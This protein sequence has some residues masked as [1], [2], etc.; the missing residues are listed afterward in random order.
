[1]EIFHLS[2]VVRRF[3]VCPW[4][5]LGLLL[6]CGEHTAYRHLDTALAY[7][8]QRDYEPALA[9]FQA[10]VEARPQDAYLH[11]R[12]GWAYLK[13]ERYAD[14][15]NE[16]EQALALEPDYIAVYQDL[17]TLAEVQDMPEAA[18]GWLERAIQRAPAYMEPYRGLA[19]FYIAHDRSNE[20]M[21]LLEDAVKRWPGATWAHFRLGLL[22]QRLK[23]G[24]QAEKAFQKILETDPETDLELKLFVD[25]HAALGNVY[26]DQ[27]KYEEAVATYSKA[28]ELNPRDHSS[29]NN[30]AWVYAVQGIQLEEGIR[31]S[32]RS[33]RLR[34]DSPIYLDTL[35]ELY[36]KHGDLERAVEIIRYAISLAPKDPALKAHLQNQ[37]AKFTAAGQGKV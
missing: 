20:A 32:S 11:R 31:L 13:R 26:Y 17:A 23:W 33:L 5:L 7:E 34:P 21:R 10:A 3:R 18:I 6:G 37:L 25:A 30:L 9:A 29:L 36:F 2:E 14:A 24:E 19:Q 4:V 12:L 8:R 27:E 35:A 15:Q 1:M 16:L 22:Y 28:I